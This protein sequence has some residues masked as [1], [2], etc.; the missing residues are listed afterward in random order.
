M[1]FLLFGLM[2]CIGL[3]AT[4]GLPRSG[5]IHRVNEMH[6]LFAKTD[7]PLRADEIDLV[8][9]TMLETGFEPTDH[10]NI[11]PEL[12]M[13]V[14]F[15][16][17]TDSIYTISPLAITVLRNDYSNTAY[18][19]HLMAH[20]AKVGDVCAMEIL[21][22]HEVGVQCQDQAGNTPLHYAAI[23]NQPAATRWLLEHGAVIDAQNAKNQT[24]LYL[25]CKAS[26][27][28]YLK[29]TETETTDCRL[30]TESSL[31]KLYKTTLLLLDKGA[32]AT[33][34]PQKLI[35][36]NTRFFYHPSVQAKLAGMPIPKEGSLAYP[37]DWISPV[38]GLTGIDDPDHE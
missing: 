2:G 9:Q 33:V 34:V 36:W 11:P 13:T 23:F 21:F 25:A 29:R 16:F 26:Y 1:Y 31:A 32:D 24:P 17:Y 6:L 7:T 10:N 4:S 30:L 35:I 15:D 27:D 37:Y 38:Y 18:S 3:N 14:R 5:W 20:A 8:F 28:N 12:L 19:S 22:K